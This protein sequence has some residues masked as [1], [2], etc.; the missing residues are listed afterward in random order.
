MLKNIFKNIGVFQ[1]LKKF[2][3]ANWRCSTVVGL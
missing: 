3:E 2:K 1:I